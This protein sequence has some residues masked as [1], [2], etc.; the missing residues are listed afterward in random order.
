M[1]VFSPENILKIAIQFEAL[2]DRLICGF[3]SQITGVSDF[4][5]LTDFPKSGVL[6]IDGEVWVYKKHGLGYV[7]QERDGCIVDVHNSFERGSHVFDAHRLAEYVVSLNGGKMPDEIS[8]LYSK[9]E[10]ALED[11]EGGGVLRR[12]KAAPAAWKLVK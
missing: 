7:F 11:L 10:A 4:R 9:I 5:F 2:Q 6:E 1:L 3:F 8:G 12:V